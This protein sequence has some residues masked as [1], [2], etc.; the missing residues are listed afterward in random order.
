VSSLP[1]QL[2]NVFKL[3]ATD[4]E[5]KQLGKSLRASGFEEPGTMLQMKTVLSYVDVELGWSD[6]AVLISQPF[7]HFK[8][9]KN[10]NKHGSH[11]CCSLKF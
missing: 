8:G 3:S 7:Y 11:C 9:L 1:Q 2:S 10:N 4:D 5:M 6:I